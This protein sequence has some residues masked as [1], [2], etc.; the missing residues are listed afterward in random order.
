MVLEENCFFW[1]AAGGSAVFHPLCVAIRLPLLP[2]PLDVFSDLL[3]LLCFAMTNWE[4]KVEA[5]LLL[6][7]LLQAEL[8]LMPFVKLLAVH[9]SM[10]E[11]LMLLVD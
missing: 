1:L 3:Q 9:Q 11:M 7:A 4:S 5:V 10:S 6:V 2:T 8:E